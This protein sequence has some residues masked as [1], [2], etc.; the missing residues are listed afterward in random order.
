[1]K[2][3]TSYNNAISAQSVGFKPESVSLGTCQNG[4]EFFAPDKNNDPNSTENQYFYDSGCTELARDVVRI[5]TQTSSSSE[6]VRRT[7]KI[8]ALGNG[9]PSAV[10]TDA[11]SI[12]N[13]TF[14]KYGYAIAADGFDHAS[15][16]ELDI[17]GAKTID[18]DHELVMQPANANVNSFCSDS[19][20]FNATGIQSLGETFGWQG[21]V[22]SGGTRTVN[23]DNSVT[24]SATHAGSTFKGSIG[25]L[26]IAAGVQNTACP[27]TTPMFTLS[28]GTS[29]GA[30]SL[31][32]S[33]TYKS[34]LLTNLTITNG[35]LANGNTLNVTTNTSVSPTSNLFINGV[36]SNAG[37]QIA[38]FNVDAFGDGTLTVTKSGAQYVITDW[39]VVK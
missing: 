15:V 1:M 27:I 5:Y 16:D 39:H 10:R 29:S 33:A 24:W 17:A 23:T 30:Y 19:A 20:G 26:S 21:G 18:A 9:T 14:D 35:T 36:V 2:N 13:A 7:E 31:P 12:L 28:G 32:I 3:I 6:T 8:Y 25:S 38:T 37:T 22:L 11:V 34:G 4:Q